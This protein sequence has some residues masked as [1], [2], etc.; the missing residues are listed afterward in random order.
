VSGQVS[1][2]VS[3]SE[4]KAFTIQV[5]DLDQRQQSRASRWLSTRPHTTKSWCVE[6]EKTKK[7]RGGVKS[8][9]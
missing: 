5:G 7:R 1:E 4:R 3:E 2:Q 8:E 6:E 9:K